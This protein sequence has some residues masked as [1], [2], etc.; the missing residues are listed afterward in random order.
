MVD[1]K[2]TYVRNKDDQTTINKRRDKL[3]TIRVID[4]VIH[5]LF[6]FNYF[7]GTG[8][9]WLDSTVNTKESVTTN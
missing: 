6:M 3:T 7:D 9:L 4:R 8:V 1:G 2:S 5:K